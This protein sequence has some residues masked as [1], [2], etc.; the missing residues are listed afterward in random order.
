M[1]DHKWEPDFSRG[2]CTG[3][4]TC[5]ICGTTHKTRIED[6][7][8]IDRQYLQICTLRA[9]QDAMRNALRKGD[10]PLLAT[11][12]SREY[13]FSTQADRDQAMRM[14]RELFNSGRASAAEGE[15]K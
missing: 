10:F 8:L 3:C 4:K 1:L 7:A 6:A 2:E 14:G 11:Q 5:G 12:L 13:N 9:D 15:T